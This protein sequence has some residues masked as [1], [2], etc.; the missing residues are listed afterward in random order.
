MKRRALLSVLISFAPAGIAA[1]TAAQN[2][3]SEDAISCLLT[4]T[5]CIP[6]FGCIGFQ[7]LLPVCW[8]CVACL[9]C[10]DSCTSYLPC[11]AT[12][13][14]CSNTIMWGTP[15]RPRNWIMGTETCSSPPCPLVLVF[16]GWTM[17]DDDIRSHSHMDSVSSQHG[18]AIVAYPDG[19]GVG[20]Y[21][22]WS[23]PDM[24][25]LGQCLFDMGV[26]DVGFINAL[27]DKLISR[28][29]VDTDRIYVTGFSNGGMMAMSLACR[30]SHRI[31]GF[32]AVGAGPLVQAYA[33]G[34]LTVNSWSCPWAGSISGMII[35]GT[36]DPATSHG[37]AASTAQWFASQLGYTPSSY[38]YACPA[39]MT[40]YSNVYTNDGAAPAQ[41]AAAISLIKVDG[42]SHNWEMFP[43]IPTPSP[44]S[45][46]RPRARGSN[47]ANSER[48]Y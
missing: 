37:N 31:A 34:E 6:C 29:D 15:P 17:T 47:E 38:E 25:N 44:C 20:Q 18:G 39:G 46:A 7:A 24:A 12:E 5:P 43:S 2:C 10:L 4:C 27:L 36:L 22:C 23:I 45:G 26:D 19:I 13:A 33:V 42:G 40:C 35:H 21:S 28:Y 48:R 16:H 32:G 9:G 11:F 30:L 8:G 41:A 1:Q 14:D 3:C